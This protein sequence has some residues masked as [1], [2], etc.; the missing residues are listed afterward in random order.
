MMDR[1]FKI[2][3]KRKKDVNKEE[4]YQ[5]G[6]WEKDVDITGYEIALENRSAFEL[7]GLDVE[8]CIYYEQEEISHRKE[9]CNQGAYCGDLSVKFLAPRSEKLL[10]TGEVTVY[11]EELDSGAFYT[12]GRDNVQRGDVHGI[13]IRVHLKLPSG[14]KRTREYC[15]PDSLGNSKAWMTSSIR[16]GMN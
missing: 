7:K 5:N 6:Y 15:L 13:W 1:Y 3:A 11:K 10:R 4:S 12:D 14:E 9:V 16:A 8:Y 2:S